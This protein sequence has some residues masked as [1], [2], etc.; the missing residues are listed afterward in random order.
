VDATH[1]LK[2]RSWVE[3]AND[4]ASDFPIQNLP[5]G[6]F[7]RK[8]SKEAPRG[9]VAIGEQILDLA[10]V[11]LKTGPNLNKL[12]AAGR[13]AWKQLRKVL[14]LGLSD[15][16]RAK[17]FS[18]W[19]VPMRKAELFLPVAIGDYSDFY[20]G[21]HH[22]LAIGRMFR[23][24]NPL[25]PN[26][27]WVPIGYH[28][29]ASS[30][31][32]SGTPVT[33]PNGQTKAPDAPAPS[34]GPAKRLDYEVEL[35]FVIGPGSALG[36]PVGIRRALDHVFGVVLMNDWSARDLQAWEY[37]PLGPF[38]AKSFATTISPW[39]VTLEALEPFRCPAFARA[40]DDPRPLPYLLD[41]ADQARG[42]FAI[43]TTMSL[44]SAQMRARKEPPAR[45]SRCSWRDGYWTIA[46]IVAHQASNGCNLA[47][48][49]LLGSGTISGTGPGTAGSL[50]ELTQG[51]KQAL[52][53]PGGETR[54]FI[55]DGDLVVQEGRCAKDGAVAIGFGQAAGLV[56]PA[57]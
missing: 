55:Q 4:P 3:S 15:P 41:A 52:E 44:Q 25:L 23:P 35:G 51:G 49:D 17:Q 9:G 30:V 20:T 6:V 22:A 19:L 2:L 36:K 50:I 57:P 32:V 37:Q 31:V 48:G 47:P 5:F 16:K 1:S 40:A 11:G 39:I 33:R 27:K 28:G 7:R 34:F 14:S 12:A 45:L 54:T 42:G 13:P 43:E 56:R 26:Y 18:K 24:D 53:L 10:A 8:A 46:Q 29:R 38:L 21:I